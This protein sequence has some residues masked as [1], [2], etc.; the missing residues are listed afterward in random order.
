LCHIVCHVVKVVKRSPRFRDVLIV[1]LRRLFCRARVS[2]CQGDKEFFFGLSF[3]R[4]AT[5]A[6]EVRQ[7]LIDFWLG[8]DN[9]DMSS[10]YAKQLT[11]DMEF[12][13]DWTK[14]VGLGF[15]LKGL[16]ESESG[17]N[18]ATCAAEIV[19]HVCVANA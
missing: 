4:S 1:E 9:P 14:R 7:L 19:E 3:S 6:I 17:V 15:E 11:E 5:I 16:L 10:R 2:S 8:H 12:R 13:Q 18:C